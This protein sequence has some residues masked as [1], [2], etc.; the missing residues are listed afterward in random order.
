MANCKMGDHLGSMHLVFLWLAEIL[1]KLDKFAKFVSSA[2][3][4]EKLEWK[5]NL[6][7]ISENQ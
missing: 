3:I 6:Y 2:G 4:L 1:G 5:R 7:Y